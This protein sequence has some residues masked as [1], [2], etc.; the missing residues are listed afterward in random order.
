MNSQPCLPLAISSWSGHQ[1]IEA[2][3]G[4]EN[5]KSTK[6]KPAKRMHSSDLGSPSK[7]QDEISHAKN[8]KLI[9]MSAIFGLKTNINK[10]DIKHETKVHTQIEKLIKYQSEQLCLLTDSQNNIGKQIA[11]ALVVVN[12]S[13]V[14]LDELTTIVDKVRTDT[15][16]VREL[17]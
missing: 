4:K 3:K 13:N 1:G 16:D 2:V 12:V 6:R 7:S 17:K 8:T 10:C 5:K 9:L 14:R 15:E 11:K